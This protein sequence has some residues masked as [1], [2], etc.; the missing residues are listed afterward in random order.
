[1]LSVSVA[2]PPHWLPR[3]CLVRGFG[4]NPTHDLL[5]AVAIMLGRTIRT[6][7]AVGEHTMLWQV[8]RDALLVCMMLAVLGV[9]YIGFVHGWDRV[10]S[11]P[12]MLAARWRRWTARVQ[13]EERVEGQTG[14]T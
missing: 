14:P 9:G 8:A 7:T 12:G 13:Q 11:L 3:A 1:M 6:V 2:P 10:F 4:A 5:S